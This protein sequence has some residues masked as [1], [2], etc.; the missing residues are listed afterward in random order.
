[1]SCYKMIFFVKFKLT[2]FE[3]EA[4]KTC[5]HTYRF[6]GR[7]SRLTWFRQLANLGLCSKWPLELANLS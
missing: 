3:Y 5:I 6:N 1:M 7:F 4:D 2:H